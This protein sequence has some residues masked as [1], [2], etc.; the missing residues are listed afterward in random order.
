MTPS[1]PTPRPVPLPPDVHAAVF[2]GLPT[3]LAHALRTPEVARAVTRLLDAGW[4][5][6]QLASRVGALPS[7]PDPAADVL[8]LLHRLADQLAPDRVWAREKA[9][10]STPASTAE[11][12]QPASPASRERWLRQ[13]RE[14]L[15]LPRRSAPEAPRPVRRPCALCGSEGQLFVTRAVRLCTGCV[16]TLESGQCRLE[17]AG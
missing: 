12:E 2:G 15:A 11:A 14:E 10:R 17:V 3:A 13:I 16:A 8:A 7:G 9:A 4:R 1:V 6:G 5:P